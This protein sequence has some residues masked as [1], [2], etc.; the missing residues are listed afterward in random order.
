MGRATVLLALAA[1]AGAGCAAPPRAP[2]VLLFGF[3][4]VRTDVL[5]D[6]DTPNLDSLAAAG[7]MR[8]DAAVTSARHTTSDTISGPGWSSILCG[9]WADKHGV[10]D[11]SFEGADYGSWPNF[12]ARLEA[13]DPELDTAAFVVWPQLVD[14]IVTA[15]GVDVAK[16]LRSP[17]DPHYP[18]SDELSAAA[19][20]AAI[21]DGADALFVYFGGCDGMGH[22]HGYAT[23]V[24][25][26]R[27]SIAWVDRLVGDVVAAV[28]ARPTFDEED[29]L[30]VATTDHGGRGT[31][32]SNGRGDAVVDRVFFLVAPLAGTDAFDPDAVPAEVAIVDAA[33][34]ALAHMGVELDGLG[35]DGR[36]VGLAPR[37]AR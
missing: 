13:R 15:G 37:E 5:L 11:N 29:W 35:L 10:D 32:H 25:E 7:V 28:R 18:G 1:V 22:A 23:D 24:P 3:D 2:R 21:G 19:A 16:K 34:T 26:Y 14:V 33:A 31:G 8:T 17:D 6:V 27:A 4:G 30:V 36:P 9:V 12:L 20:V